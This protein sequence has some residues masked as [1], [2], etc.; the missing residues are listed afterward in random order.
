M[1][2]ILQ[3]LPIL[4]LSEVFSTGAPRRAQKTLCRSGEKDGSHHHTH[5]INDMRQPLLN[6]FYHFFRISLTD[7]NEKHKNVFVNMQS[8]FVVLRFCVFIRLYNRTF[9]LMEDL[10]QMF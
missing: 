3:K 2:F 7:P 6:I 9:I 10:R 5:I 1:R 8:H 4:Y